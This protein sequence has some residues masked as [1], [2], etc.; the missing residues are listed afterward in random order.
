MKSKN[1]TSGRAPTEKIVE[2]LE[3]LRKSKSIKLY[4]EREEVMNVVKDLALDHP[5]LAQMKSSY[6]TSLV[7]A[8]ARM[9][10]ED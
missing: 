1:F 2:C 9:G 8:V 7:N 6:V 3:S 5:R 4:K 10:I